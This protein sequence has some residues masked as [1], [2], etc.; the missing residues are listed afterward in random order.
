MKLQHY[1]TARMVTSMLLLL[2]LWADCPADQVEA[3]SSSAVGWTPRIVMS[4]TGLAGSRGLNRRLFPSRSLGGGALAPDIDFV[5]G[6]TSWAVTEP[7]I[8][9]WLVTESLGYQPGSGSR[10]SAQLFYNQRNPRS[11]DTRVFSTGNWILNW[12]NYLVVDPN[13]PPSVC[14]YVGGGGTRSYESANNSYDAG[15]QSELLAAPPGYQIAY[16]DGSRDEYCYLLS[17]MDGTSYAFRTAQVNSFNQTNLFTYTNVN[18]QIRLI[19]VVDGDGRTNIVNYDTTVTTISLIKEIIDPFNRT[20]RF[21]Y[22]SNRKLTNIVNVAGLS[23]QYA[24]D[25]NGWVTNMVTPQSLNPFSFRYV[26]ADGSTMIADNTV[27][28]A[29]EI[30][31]PENQKQLYVYRQLSS[32]LNATDASLILPT[33]Y[34]QVPTNANNTY[35]FDN[36]TIRY[37]N[38]FYWNSTRYAALSASFR[39][40]FDFSQMTTND[41]LLARVR[42]W[43]QR[44][45]GKVSSILSSQR[46]GS[47]DGVQE[48][49]ITW[50]DYKD[51]AHCA[52]EG[53]SASPSA[54]A[55]VMP[56][57][58]SRIV[59]YAY[60]EEFNLSSMTN[61]FTD[62]GA[63]QTQTY[64]WEYA[65][66]GM[67]VITAR[68]TDSS[69]P[70]NLLLQGSYGYNDRHQLTRLTNAVNEVT[71]FNYD[72]LGRL[73]NEVSAFGSIRQYEYYP[74][75][76]YT[77]WIQ[78]VIDVQIGRTNSIAY[79]NGL[80][81][82]KTDERGLTLS[83]SWDP[84]QRLTSVTFPDNTYVSNC[85]LGLNLVLT[86]D[87]VGN[88]STFAYDDVGRV[89]AQTDAR[90]NTTSIAY[91]ACGSPSV[92]I[93]P[94]NE[95]LW[96]DYDFRGNLT[97][98]VYADGTARKHQFN[99][100]G[101]LVST[102]DH[103]NKSYF[104]F[105]NNMGLIT[106]V[107]NTMGK[108]LEIT[109]DLMNRPQ[110]VANANGMVVEIAYDALGRATNVAYPQ[111]M[112]SERYAYSATGLLSHVDISNVKK[113]YGYDAGGRL[114]SL[115][116]TNNGAARSITL[117]NDVSDN[118]VQLMDEKGQITKWKYDIYSQVT[119]KVVSNIVDQVLFSFLYNA[120]GWLTNRTSAAKGAISYRHDAVGNCTN[121][122]PASGTAISVQ[123]DALNRPTNIT[124]SIGITRLNYTS[125][126]AF[127][128]ED[129]PWDQDTVTYGYTTNHNLGSI[130]IQTPG[131]ASWTQ[132]YNY[133]NANRLTSIVSPSGTFSYDYTAAA[134]QGFIGTLIKKLGLPNAS[135]ITNIFDANGRLSSTQLRSPS[136]S[137]INSHG[138]EYGNS[139]IWRQTRKDNNTVEYGY[140]DIGQ[141]VTATGKE[142]GTGQERKNERLGYGYDLAENLTKRT[143]NDSIVTFAI[144][145]ANQI[146]AASRNNVMTV[147]GATESAVSSVNISVNGGGSNAATRYADNSYAKEAV[148]VINGNNTITAVATDSQNRSASASSTVFLPASATYSYDNNGNLVS[149]GQKGYE[150]DSFD[151]L[152]SVTA[153][154]V[155][156]TEYV[157][158]AVRRLRK[159]KEY[160]WQNNQ[161]N[162]ASEK[163]YIYDGMLVIQERDAVNKPST[164][165]TRG[166]DLSGGL[167][168]AGGIGGLLART[169]HVGPV[170]IN[171]YYHADAGGNITC[172]INSNQIVVARYLYDPFGN[173]IAAS[174]PMAQVNKYRFSSKEFQEN[175]GLYYYGYRSYDPSL[176]RWL[177]RDPLGEAGGINLYGFVGNDPINLIDDSGL[178]A[179]G[180]TVVK[181][182]KLVKQRRAVR[183]TSIDDALR[184]YKEG[185]E[186]IKCP[187]KDAAKE[188]ARRANGGSPPIYEKDKKTGE[189]HY[190]PNDRSSHF[191]WGLAGALTFSYYA[192]GY[193]TFAELDAAGLDMINPLS[194]PQDIL[195]IKD[196][197]YGSDE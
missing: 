71:Q 69:N 51:K 116:Y 64:A 50:L 155:W 59:E 62:A 127:L 33:S 66:N 45:D 14:D 93:N 117:S 113:T 107:S 24:Y 92:I 177:N 63:V 166:K 173:V 132:N 61:I 47:P 79:V 151:Q 145:N 76:N 159:R 184:L 9:L 119:N 139:R 121:I 136:G 133:D 12:Q 22:N 80:P 171:S 36:L 27:N 10:I 111:G 1:S 129:G 186:F 91:C 147:A 8:N 188:A 52:Y 115:V 182:I 120:N 28:R 191:L 125:Y 104:L 70:Q 168:R 42:H 153:T 38:T 170:N 141:L 5:R 15:S 144:T 72:S 85:Y 46:N 140:D 194:L 55:K 149:D 49:Q 56:D 176:Q 25:T 6:T 152:T 29:V 37:R 89:S 102:I 20:N 39:N 13:N 18:G 3:N 138:Y 195:D 65:P 161:Y 178:S 48:G 7:Y 67:D 110:V 124:D 123:Y 43:L 157:Y 197:L 106:C 128:S 158:D 180:K 146:T 31:D 94:L 19:R 126:G 82:T 114:T 26:A 192:E 2:A 134:G 40:S 137:I 23:C 60:N 105:Y 135:F 142:P 17:L 148:T 162:L 90:S 112:G 131:S 88:T 74:T 181:I 34:G 172:L 58:T 30:T 53:T 81:S 4:R 101:Q 118:V 95:Y 57:G 97:N 185:E 169:D 41:F 32:Q 99:K 160:Q 143:N 150:Y 96:K 78:K 193:G 83:F 103:A 86:K 190:H 189:K 21:Y 175:S 98:I 163:R 122:S 164:T 179:I 167:R 187:A 54:I 35:N 77:N 196:A 165:F 68:A 156:R 109:Y 130:T 154:N 16:P 183:A 44:H 108:M 174:G 75:G 87:R 11:E 84:L 73:T 100:L